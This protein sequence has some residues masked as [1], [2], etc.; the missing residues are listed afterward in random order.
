[1]ICRTELHDMFV[2][3]LM[4]WDSCGFGACHPDQVLHDGNV[5]SHSDKCGMTTARTP[6]GSTLSINFHDKYGDVRVD[7]IP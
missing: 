3:L 1:M 2:C 5:V 6:V 7:S 4:S